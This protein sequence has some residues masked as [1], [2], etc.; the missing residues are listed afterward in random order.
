MSNV[1]HVIPESNDDEQVFSG[2]IS[3]KELS[4]IKPITVPGLE[5]VFASAIA[6]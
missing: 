4:I 5:A 1:S 3:F 6:S 2:T